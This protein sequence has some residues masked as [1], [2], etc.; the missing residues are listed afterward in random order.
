MADK[1]VNILLLAFLWFKMTKPSAR[2]CSPYS[3]DA[4]QLLGQLVREGRLA[5]AFTTTELATRAG[6]SRAL[7]QRIEKGDPGCSIGAVFET[8]A[9]CGV[10]L[11]ES[12]KRLLA[13]TLARQSEK[14]ALL[15]KA[16]RA[17]T[18]KVN[19]DF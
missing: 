8:A 11:F 7:L 5:R 19:D 13:A 1:Q 18:R 3:R 2:P 12:D 17:G 16:V 4:L 14:M 15:P 9:I 6:I 10:P